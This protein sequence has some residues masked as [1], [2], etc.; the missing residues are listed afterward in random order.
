MSAETSG[1]VR[2]NLVGRSSNSHFADLAEKENNGDSSKEMGHNIN[3]V[4]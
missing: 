4:S 1:R 2:C 3:L